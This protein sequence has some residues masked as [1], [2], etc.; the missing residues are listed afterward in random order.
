MRMY[1]FIRWFCCWWKD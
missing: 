1:I